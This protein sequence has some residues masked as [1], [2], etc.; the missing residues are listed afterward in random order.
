MNPDQ[1]EL[2]VSAV[3]YRRPEAHLF[4]QHLRQYILVQDEDA[5]KVMERIDAL[6][7]NVTGI[8]YKR[9]FFK[10][11]VY[12]KNE[13]GTQ[14]CEINIFRNAGEH[15]K[16]IKTGLNTTEIIPED[17]VNLQFAIEFYDT[18]RYF[19]ELFR[20]VTDTYSAETIRP[21]STA[22]LNY[23]LFSF[24]SWEDKEVAELNAGEE[25]EDE[26]GYLRAQEDEQKRCDDDDYYDDIFGR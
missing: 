13:R 18:S 19:T 14:Q 6:L 9:L 25:Q 5:E 12:V 1:I 3:T 24:Y 4:I 8:K 26:M 17:E 20:Y 16:G 23:G 11:D 22:D 2:S 7:K 15:K 21:F 10:F